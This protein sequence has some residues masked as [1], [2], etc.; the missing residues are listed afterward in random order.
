MA[1]TQIR[2][3]ELKNKIAQDYFGG[4]DCTRIIGNID[5]CV[6]QPQNGLFETQSLLWAEA[7]KGKADLAKSI[8]QLVLT[9]G[10]ARTFDKQLPPSY[11]G[12][13]DAENIAFVPYSEV[14]EIFYQNDFNWNVTPSN[15]DTKEFQQV[16]Q[17]VE[18]ILN[19]HALQFA[20]GEDDQELK[21]FIQLNFVEGKASFSKIQIDKNNFLIIYNKWLVTV[22]PTIAINWEAAK[23][24]GIIDADF[25]LADLLSKDNDS[26]K[27]TLSVLLK[28]DYYESHRQLDEIGMFASRKTFFADKQKA[29]TQFWNKYQRPP[30]EEYWDYIIERRDLL[31]PQDIR[32]R[33]GSFFTPQIWVELSQKYLADVLG[34]N[35]Q[36]EYYIWDCAAGT[37]NLLTGLTNK[38]RIFASTLDRQ[39]VDVIKDRIQNGANLWEDHVFQFDF[40]NDSFDKLPKPLQQIVNDPEK[41]KKLVI[42]INPPYAESNGRISVD[43]SKV[44]VSAIH[45][46]YSTKLEKVGAELFAQFLA[47][48]YFELPDCI[49]GLF[50]TLK[51]ISATNSTTFRSHFLAE[52]KKLFIIP[53]N[54]FDNV[55]GKFPIG[56]FIWD[57]KQ[58]IKF[59]QITA[60]IYN[61]TNQPIG[62][63]TFYSYDNEKG[64]INDFLNQFV[65]KEE[66]GFIGILVA[67]APDFQNNN[68]IALQSA[69]GDRHGKYFWV[70]KSN[71]LITCIYFAVRHCIK[72]TWLNDR[73]QFLH[74]QDSWQ[75]DKTFQHDCLA[76]ALFHGQNKITAIEGVN[77]WLP[78][79][80]DDVNARRE[81]VSNFMVK[82]LQGK[83]TSENP[84]ALFEKDK[85]S[86]KASPLEFSPEAQAVFEAGKKLWQYYHAQ[87]NKL[88]LQAFEAHPLGD[89]G[90]VNASL[91]DIKAY[92]QGRNA[93]G[94]MNNKSTDEK[95]NELM[96]NLREV[97]K[98]L[99]Q[100]IEPK[101]YEHGFLKR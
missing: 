13:F 21:E 78:F 63:K 101:V 85:K 8:V 44:Q 3:E 53:A 22:K 47:R 43:R 66:N 80:E 99:A 95:Y 46:K 87:I 39:D 7:K 77:H 30:K 24:K 38:R 40:L 83:I 91:Y 9:I 25:Y 75:T 52:L 45:T 57:T 90:L 94:K 12:A 20:F 28:N 59:E 26:L 16:Y 34:E 49:I 15:Y 60:K 5:F 68:F 27:E 70:N 72:A 11:L 14:Q 2:E 42:Y 18:N 81:F 62:A 6:T 10:K 31:V 54:T 98:V 55:K 58:K 64:R 23:N 17:K 93:Q 76:F 1:Y 35:W 33:K 65:R 51:V 69:K 61:T 50:S 4:F 100:K 89:E 19:T 92:F 74:P 56:F 71:L 97:L 37:G 86:T 41:R 73:D 67:D 84:T 48:I 29:H 36:D 32:E 79:T 88:S 96:G 82:F